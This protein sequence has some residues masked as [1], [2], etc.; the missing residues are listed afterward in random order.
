M[1]DMVSDTLLQ[2]FQTLNLFYVR[3]NKGKRRLLT[4]RLTFLHEL[5]LPYSRHMPWKRLCVSA[6]PEAQSKSNSTLKELMGNIFYTK[7]VL[8]AVL[9]AAQTVYGVIS[10]VQAKPPPFSPRRKASP[11][12]TKP[13]SHSQPA[14]LLLRKSWVVVVTKSGIPSFHISA[15]VR[16]G[17]P[18]PVSDVRVFLRGRGGLLLP[19]RGA[20]SIPARSEVVFY[21]SV[22]EL[23][24]PRSEVRCVV[25]CREC[26]ARPIL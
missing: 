20:R 2:F 5:N 1:L 16:N 9:V 7:R 12:V 21:L 25:T 8:F 11:L 22:R 26:S 19:M 24:E 4:Q 14:H 18:Y 17:E 10:D 6:R 3:G 15:V 23:F 13:P